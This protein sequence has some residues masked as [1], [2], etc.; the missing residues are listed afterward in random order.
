MSRLLDPFKTISCHHFNYIQE[1]LVTQHHARLLI[2]LSLLAP[3]LLLLDC[4][5]TF[6]KVNDKQLQAAPETLQEVSDFGTGQML[7][8]FCCCECQCQTAAQSSLYAGPYC[9]LESFLEYFFFFSELNIFH[10]D[11]LGLC[12]K[13]F[14]ITQTESGKLT[15]SAQCSAQK[16][17]H[18][19][20][21]EEMLLT[22][23]LEDMCVLLS[24]VPRGTWRDG[25]RS[26]SPRDCLYYSL[27]DGPVGGVLTLYEF[28]KHLRF[29]V[30]QFCY[31]EGNYPLS[32]RKLLRT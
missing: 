6:I 31:W 22:Q 3:L 28:I 18:M 25:E 30:L 15:I 32:Q 27:C 19:G 13:D 16:Y 8:A 2:L 20:K 4:H 21:S 1:M 24:L 5:C 26:L 7:E 17:K 11:F 23:E 14:G 29:L 12:S 9:T 10:S